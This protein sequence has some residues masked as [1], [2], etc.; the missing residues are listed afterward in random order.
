MPA[1]SAARSKAPLG[2]AK[3]R[4]AGPS[5]TL[6]AALVLLVLLGGG[7]NATVVATVSL[8]EMVTASRLIVEGT[9]VELSTERTPDGVLTTRVVVEA[10]E[11]FKD[12]RDHRAAAGPGRI[13]FHVLG[14]EQD[15]LQLSM[16]GMPRFTEGDRAVFL[17]T[18]RTRRGFRFPVGLGQG[19]L[20]LTTEALGDVRVSR[21][22]EGLVM[23][24]GE[25][26]PVSEPQA[27]PTDYSTVAARLRE[28]VRAAPGLR[29][30]R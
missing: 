12:A 29:P 5:L 11:V 10:G 15:G 6:L 22:L 2:R 30:D 3:G 23:V 27:L 18:Q 25:G 17:L 13:A 28:L 9:V 4:R 21:D 14:G 7:L 16:P 20:R 24:S 19:V 1:P 8:A 26:Q